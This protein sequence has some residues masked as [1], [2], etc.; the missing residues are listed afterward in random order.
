MTLIFLQDEQ[1]EQC[2]KILRKHK[3]QRVCLAST[4]LQRTSQR[5]HVPTPESRSASRERWHLPSTGNGRVTHRWRVEGGLLGG[6]ERQEALLP[7]GVRRCAVHADGQAG[8]GEPLVVEQLRVVLAGT[9][10]LACDRIG[11]DGAPG[12]ATR[13]PGGWSAAMKTLSRLAWHRDLP[14][15]HRRTVVGTVRSASSFPSKGAG[16][17]GEKGRHCS[18]FRGTA[19]DYPHPASVMFPSVPPVWCGLCVGGWLSFKGNTGKRL[20]C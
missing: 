1:H 2:N 9:H 8:G 3:G 18:R 7:C 20:V 11:Q 4:S 15:S 17:R 10:R 6:A 14:E 12:L 13:R 16:G 19:K 5:A